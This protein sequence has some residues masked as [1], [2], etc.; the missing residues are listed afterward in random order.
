MSLKRIVM[1]CLVSCVTPTPSAWAQSIW[2]SPQYTAPDYMELFQPQSPWASA[3]SHVSVLSAPASFISVHSDSELQQMFADLARRHIK[4]GL[5]RSP[6]EGRPSAVAPQ[7][8]VGVEGFSAPPEALALARKIKRL[9]GTVGYYT[10]DEP[11]YFGRFYDPDPKL[12]FPSKRNG[13]H[14]SINDI[15]EDAAKRIRDVR[16]VFPGVKVGDVEPFMEFSDSDWVNTLSQWFDAYHTA[17]G[18]GSDASF[19]S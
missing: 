16:S 6:L 10:M 7:C 19:V 5:A 8:G 18:V 14:L 3:A 2:F 12:G 11:L 15:A 4:F 13:C 17:T 9:G 1:R